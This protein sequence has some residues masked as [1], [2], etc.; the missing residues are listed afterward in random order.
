MAYTVFRS[1]LLEGTNDG[2]RLVSVE[3][4]DAANKP[5]A[6]ENGSLVKIVGL[7]DGEREVYKAVAPDADTPLEDLAVIG[8][9]EVM[10]DERK[11][12][13]SDFINEA[14]VAARGYLLRARNVY[15]V[16]KEGLTG[17]A[18]PAVGNV[19]ELDGT[20]KGKVVAASTSATVVGTIMAVESTGRY[21]YYVVN[22][23]KKS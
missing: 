6:I 1:D 3:F 19:V 13:L 18:T 14:G 21:T 7:L 10:Y 4:Y 16:T 9:P 15:S 17:L 23:G 2:S 5:A 8:T 22:V 11:K 12:N 20:T